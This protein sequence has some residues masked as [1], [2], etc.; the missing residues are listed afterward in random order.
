M[1]LRGTD[2]LNQLT[3]RIIGACIEVHRHLGPGLLEKIYEQCLVDELELQGLRSQQQ[4]AVPIRYKGRE[5]AQGYRLDL[6]VEGIVI[7]EVKAV[8]SLEPVHQ[9]QALT[10]LRLSGLP[11]ALLVNFHT[12]LLRSG[13]RR[14]L[15]RMNPEQ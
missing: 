11:V 1:A 15:N 9:A 14:F 12:P 5:L 8:L 3:E 10:Y 2:E 6:V 4:V 7:V 13:L